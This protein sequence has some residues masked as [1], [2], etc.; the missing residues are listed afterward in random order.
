MTISQQV[1][2]IVSLKEESGV[3]EGGHDF[4]SQF[5]FYVFAINTGLVLTEYS[6]EKLVGLSSC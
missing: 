3:M 1:R 5:D 2:D 4:L 6:G